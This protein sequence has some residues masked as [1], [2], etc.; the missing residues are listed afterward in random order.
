MDSLVPFSELLNIMPKLFTC[1]SEM[2][3]KSGTGLQLPLSSTSPHLS[4]SGSGPIWL[5]AHSCPW[6]VLLQAIQQPPATWDQCYGYCKIVH[7]WQDGW[8]EDTRFW[9]GVS[10]LCVC[11]LASMFM[12]EVCLLSSLVH[13][14]RDYSI[15]RYVPFRSDCPRC[16]DAEEHLF[17]PYWAE[18]L[19]WTAECSC[20]FPLQVPEA[21]SKHPHTHTH[22]Q[23]G[24]TMTDIFDLF[25]S[26]KTKFINKY[27][28]KNIYY[29]KGTTAFSFVC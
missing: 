14:W 8:L 19:F 28:S 26:N 3:G 23:T 13:H 7:K 18:R 12:T 20:P 5:E 29:Y 25:F 9:Q 16:E 17:S 11:D 27:C 22:N 6:V 1:F 15:L 4:I 21:Y 24:N 10:A 2:D